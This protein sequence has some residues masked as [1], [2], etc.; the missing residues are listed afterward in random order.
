M[1]ASPLIAL[2]P[3][4]WAGDLGAVVSLSSR[5]TTGDLF[6]VPATLEFGQHIIL[7]DRHTS[8]VIVRKAIYQIISSGNCPEIY[9]AQ[10]P[11]A[12]IA[13]H[14]SLSA[15][16]LSM[17]IVGTSQTWE[18]WLERQSQQRLSLKDAVEI[19]RV[20]LAYEQEPQRTVELGTLRIRCAEKSYD[21]NNL[22]RKLENGG[23]SSSGDS[24]LKK[25]SLR[26][27]AEIARVILQ[28][29]HEE[30][31]SN[32]KL[33]EIRAAC[34]MG[35]GDWESKI[36]KPLKRDLEAQRFK[37]D[38]IHVLGIDDP[39]ERIRQQA[40]LAPRYQMSAAMLGQAIAAMKQRT[41]TQEVKVYD[42]D[43]LF[44]LES[45]GIDWLIPELLPK[46]ETIILA[47]SPK[48]GKT[49]LAIDAAF[50]LATGESDFLGE[51]TKRGKVL[52][53]SVDE[54]L[55]ST[56][57]KLLKRGF[58]HK[59]K[60]YIRVLP[61]WTIDQMG[62]LEAELEDFRPDVVIVDS[63]RRINHGSQISENS[64]E[65]ADN[66]YTLKETCG[67]YGASSIL[68][69]H[70]NKDS[71]AL[72]VGRLRGSSAIAGAV[73][74]TWQLDHIPK[75]DPNNKKKLI[76]DP[77]DPKRVLSVFARDTEG[78]TFNI[79]FNPED[80]SWVRCGS[81][82]P[83]AQEEGTLK[84]RILRILG[85]NQSGLSG[86]EII[87][88][89][90]MTKEEGRGVYTT[91]SR[92]GS[93]RIISCKPA[94]GDKRYNIYTLPTKNFTP[95]PPIH[96]DLNVE[97]SSK[98]LNQHDLNN[99]QHNT[100]HP[101]KI[102][103]HLNELISPV[104]CLNQDTV[105]DVAILNTCDEKIGRG[106]DLASVE[107]SETES[108]SVLYDTNQS[109]PTDTLTDKLPIGAH[110]YEPVSLLEIEQSGGDINEYVDCEVEVRSCING[111]VNSVGRL[112]SGNVSPEGNVALITLLKGEEIA[113]I[114]EVYLI[115]NKP[116]MGRLLEVWENVPLL[117]E[118]AFSA[119]PEQLQSAL[120]QCSPE[121]VDCINNAVFE[122]VEASVVWMRDFLPEMDTDTLEVSIENWQ[123]KFLQAVWKRLT[124]DERE[125]LKRIAANQADRDGDSDSESPPSANSHNSKLTE[126][127]LPASEQRKELI[128]YSIERPLVD[129]IRELL[130]EPHKLGELILS[131]FVSESELHK[132]AEQL[133][134]E[135]IACI[136]DAANQAW[137]PGLN[138]D[139]VFGNERVEII[140][141]G[142]IREIKIKNQ[143]GTYSKVKRSNLR[144]WLGKLFL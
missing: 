138:R 77:A 61:Q 13:A 64:A 82:T 31:E 127:V 78:Q 57:S 8:E 136:K 93:K 90:G 5:F 114:R 97:Y 134:H 128:Q 124:P 14:E 86:N 130:N 21:W 84:E 37:L 126:P 87:E 116:L 111:K 91:L 22:I 66:I 85:I 9:E 27:A 79:E 47:A 121:Q 142:Q 68:I 109:E 59:D 24:K 101:L 40:L 44:D 34:G 42:L 7:V 48:A 103:Q 118:L 100:Q 1:V 26:E 46:G 102:T 131:R 81:D 16:E 36:I 51:T 39:V 122:L 115:G 43:E 56:K 2:K 52:L 80:N 50:A 83:E 117:G 96:S 120:A 137:H 94:P 33:E 19:A 132:A 70:N 99:T 35:S 92:M 29:Q 107:Y 71:E 112:S 53:I 139:A 135:Q 75:K 133:T 11:I 3:C 119:T 110:H 38:L 125:A 123:P 20:I 18:K 32:L 89:L 55:N 41:F 74:G 104:E 15:G 98:S 95:P 63:L 17:Q 105:S 23:Q 113:H 58:R 67:R 141:A 129:R 108:I 69:H 25:L 106:G 143:S 12:I 73:W 54:S 62:I 30:L 10:Q 45:E 28:A 60:E 140:E 144:P 65:F 88:L 4:L 6:N 76:I 49:L 72:G